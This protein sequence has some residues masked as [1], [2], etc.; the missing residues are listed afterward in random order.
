MQCHGEMVE[1]FASAC[2]P[3][4]KPGPLPVYACNQSMD[5]T[6]TS[7]RDEAKT[8]PWA[9]DASKCYEE[10]GWFVCDV[11]CEKE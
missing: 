4:Y 5:C 2:N 11:Q 9:F 1:H 10:H 3:G 7:L 8:E 6:S